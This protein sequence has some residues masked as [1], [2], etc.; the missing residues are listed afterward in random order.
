MYSL[1]PAFVSALFLGFGTY[2]LITEGATRVS[3]P[4]AVMCVTTFVWQGTWALLFQATSPDLAGLLVKIGYLFILFLPTTFYHFVVEVVARRDERPLLLA[5]YALSAVLAVLLVTS[6][7]VVDGFGSYFFGYYPR[8]GRLHPLHVAQTV[9][10]VCRAAWLL[11][12]ARRKITNAGSRRLLDLCLVSLGLYSLA[13]TD[14][15]VNYGYELY[16]LGVLFITVSLGMLAV[17]I[18]RYGLMGPYLT[19]ATVA[20]EVATP[21]ATIGL[22]A[23]ELRHAL[24]EL[25]RGY[26]LAVEHR[27]VDDR[28]DTAEEPER[29]PALVS[30]IRRHVDSTNTVVEMS[31]ASLTLNRLDKRSFAVHS[32]GACVEAALERYP[33]RDGERAL[34]SV[35]Q[36]DPEIRFSGSD[37]L[38]MFVLFNLLKNAIQAIHS[39]GEGRIE[40]A[41]YRS[42]G[43]CVLRFSDSGPGIAPDVLPQIFDPFYSTKAHGR[44]TGVGLTFCRRVCEAFGGGIACESAQGVRTTFTLQLPEPGSAADRRLRDLP[45]PSG[46]YRIG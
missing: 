34:V 26:R 41:A 5:S 31:L 7:E 29:L 28:L 6:N 35:A 32:V 16:P 8:A 10:L 39:V 12:R 21:L 30:A 46:D 19:L 24:P 33:F 13:A 22:H 25:M 27:L 18:V 20:H 2:V 9:F 14:Y 17:S 44:G 3:I 42:E 11:L 4:F 1:L 38:L 43:F 37:T 23:D 15:L 36:I 40:I 45:Q